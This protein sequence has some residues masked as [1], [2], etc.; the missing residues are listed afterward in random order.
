MDQ[1]LHTA[2]DAEYRQ[3]KLPGMMQQRCFSAIAFGAVPNVVA[4]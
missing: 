3:P 4:T 1:H 2:A